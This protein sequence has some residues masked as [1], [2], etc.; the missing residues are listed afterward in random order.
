MKEQ[1]EKE[2][3]EL[4][5][6]RTKEELDQLT[7]GRPS[8]TTTSS[9]SGIRLDTDGNL[10]FDDVVIPEKKPLLKRLFSFLFR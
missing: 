9:F 3:L 6:Q 10:T 7:N 2:E 1:R 5:R 8:G 4:F